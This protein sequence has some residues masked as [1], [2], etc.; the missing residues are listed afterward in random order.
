LRFKER[1]VN[2]GQGANCLSIVVEF[3]VA[4]VLGPDTGPLLAVVGE[5]VTAGHPVRLERR[6]DR[7]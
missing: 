3:D 7:R 2:T 1:G 5:T 4:A 6:A